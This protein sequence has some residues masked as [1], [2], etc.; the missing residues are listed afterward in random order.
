M[1]L[2]GLLY[3]QQGLGVGGR[4][5]GDGECV[6]WRI[7]VHVSISSVFYSFLLKMTQNDPHGLTCHKKL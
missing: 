2:L 3:L 6:G 4:G 1:N 7:R 5:G